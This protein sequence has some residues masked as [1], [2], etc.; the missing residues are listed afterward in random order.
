VQ[1]ALTNVLRHA[2]PGATARVRVREQ[3]GS[4][5]VEVADTGRGPSVDGLAEGS[6]IAGMRHRAERLGGSVEVTAR[7]GLGV[8]VTAW[9][10]LAP[11]TRGAPA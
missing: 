10:P 5:L 9:L 2:G 11:D 7:P 8:Q 6:G 4:L 3:R 1:E